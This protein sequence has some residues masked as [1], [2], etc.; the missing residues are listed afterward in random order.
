MSLRHIFPIL[1]L[2]ALTL[3]AAHTASAACTDPV[4]EEGAI[5]YNDDHNT[6]QFCNGTQWIA[7]GGG[8]GGGGSIA[9]VTSAQR[10]ALTPTAGTIVYNTTSQ[11]IEWYDGTKWTYSLSA[12]GD[13]TCDD[14][15]WI[16]N[17]LVLNMNGADGSTAFTDSSTNGFSGVA[18]GSPQI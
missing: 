8:G 7:M 18:T 4:R 3:G 11:R 6:M 2:A 17:A 14:P 1:I 10:N 16:N 15:Y 12:N 9:S 5:V 13:A